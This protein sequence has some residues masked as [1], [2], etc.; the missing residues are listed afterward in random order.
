MQGSNKDPTPVSPPRSHRRLFDADV[1]E[2]HNLVN[3]NY[4]VVM[5]FKY[6]KRKSL[7]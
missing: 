1:R 4:G 7:K 6:K 5:S 2:A 3:A